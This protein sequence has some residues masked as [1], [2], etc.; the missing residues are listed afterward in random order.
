P[1]ADTPSL[2]DA[3]PIL[4]LII[5]HAVLVRPYI[6]RHVAR[7]ERGHQGFD[8]GTVHGN[9]LEAKPRDSLP[10]RERSLVGGVDGRGA[11]VRRSDQDRKSTRL[12]SSHVKI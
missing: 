11:S 12:N 7:D 3:L 8:V 6:A 1:G 10:A 4:R 5:E 9:L 2:R